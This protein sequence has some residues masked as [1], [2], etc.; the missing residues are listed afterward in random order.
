MP[1]SLVDV[2]KYYSGVSHQTQ[3]LER[4]QQQV[5]VADSTLLAD[6]SEFVRLWRNQVVVKNDFLIASDGIGSAKV[7]MTYA[8]IQQALGPDYTYSEVSPFMVD[9]SGVAVLREG[10]SGFFAGRAIAFYLAYPANETLSDSTVINLFIT[11]NPKYKTAQGVGPGTLL[12]KAV[13]D[14]GRVLLSFNTE[15]ESREFANFERSPDKLS[16]RAEA[17]THSF[18]GDYSVPDAERSDSFNQTPAFFENASV[19]QVWV[20][21]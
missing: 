17:L 11:A 7:G 2:A 18:A 8:Q 4:L 14:Y 20:R 16:F 1:I 19:S 13:G 5:E 3:A 21:A 15:A 9:L 6:D 10:I 12:S